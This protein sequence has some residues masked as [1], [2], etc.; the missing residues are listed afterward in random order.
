MKQYK[1]GQSL[2]YMNGRRAL[3]DIKILDL[4]RVICG[5]MATM[6]LA[7]FGANII[8]IENTTTGDD[9]RA[10]APY[11]ENSSAYFAYINRNKKGITLNLKKEEGRRIF[12][13]LVK[14]VDVVVE[15]FRPGVMKKLGIGYEDCKK[16]NDKIIFASASG[17]GSYGPYSTKP[18]YDPLAQAMGGIQSLTGPIEGPPY[19]AGAAIADAS[20]AVNLA[21]GIMIALHYRDMTGKGQYFEVALVDSIISLISTDTFEYLYNGNKTRRVGNKN[22]TLS[23]YGNFKGSD[24]EFVMCCGNQKLF[25]ILC[26][27]GMKKPEL[28]DDPR[29]KTLA[30]RSEN[31][32]PLKEIVDEWTSQRTADENVELLESLG[33]PVAPILDMEQILHNPHMCDAREMFIETEHPT[34]GKVVMTGSPYKMTETPACFYHR[35]PYMGEH[36]KDILTSMLG[37]SEAEVDQLHANGVI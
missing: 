31:Y 11:V 37:I 16:V 19:K 4:T 18:G 30:L 27:D 33:I 15:N 6:I 13:E 2:E 28:I 36:N 34:L 20:T 17:F 22:A 10:W 12:L 35:A 3:E 25:E 5:P 24:K 9:T 29:F 26:R 8:K 7:D 14:Q 23:P 21:L 32:D 1:E